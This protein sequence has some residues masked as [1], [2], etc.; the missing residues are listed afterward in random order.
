[1][2]AR[3]PDLVLGPLKREKE[4][5]TTALPLSI[6]H[7]IFVL[8]TSPILICSWK[9]QVSVQT[10][11]ILILPTQTYGRPQKGSSGF[12]GKGPTPDSH[13]IGKRLAL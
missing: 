11:N 4:K 12:V 1:M 9:S 7:Y 13:P 5:I 2:V 3:T 6:C 10:G 8:E